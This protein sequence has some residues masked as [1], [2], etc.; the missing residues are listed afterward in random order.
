MWISLLIL[1]FVVVG[2]LGLVLLSNYLD[3]ED[4]K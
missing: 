3:K 1:A 4:K 2:T